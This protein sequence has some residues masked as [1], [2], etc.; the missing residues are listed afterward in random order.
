M[1]GPL[2]AP[3]FA[4]WQSSKL[5]LVR[6]YSTTKS[7][8][9]TH[10]ASTMAKRSRRPAIVLL[11]PV[12]A[13]FSAEPPAGPQAQ[14]LPP[15]AKARSSLKNLP[16]SL[17]LHPLAQRQSDSPRIQNQLPRVCQRQ[18]TSDSSIHRS[19]R[20][21]EQEQGNRRRTGWKLPPT[22]LWRLPALR[23]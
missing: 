22:M 2:P 5:L 1:A 14:L 6:P 11:V 10:P 18:S 21:R 16:G 23:R 3:R 19:F 9:L 4:N 7:A 17:R 8:E 20:P 12:V 13:A 15:Q